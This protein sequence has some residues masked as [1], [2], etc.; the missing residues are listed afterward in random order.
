GG[1]GNCTLSKFPIL[2]QHNIELRINNRKNRRGLL[3]LID[4]PEGQLNLTNW[5]LGLAERDR[6]KQVAM[7]LETPTFKEKIEL[8]T[9]IA[10]DT[11]DWRN[12]LHK[13][14]LQENGYESLAHCKSFPAYMP[15]GALDKAYANRKVAFIQGAAIRTKLARTASDHLPVLIDFS[16][17]C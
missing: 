10:G 11:N 8:P 12:T 1:Y 2:E 17:N 4:T 9:I 14:A 6:H 15:L 13:A 7:L 16:L 5:H 3:T